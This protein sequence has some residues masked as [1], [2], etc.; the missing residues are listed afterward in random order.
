MAAATDCRF[1][2]TH[3]GGQ[4]TKPVPLQRGRSLMTCGGSGVPQESSVSLESR[5]KTLHME[6]HMKQ[7]VYYQTCFS[8]DFSN[9]KK[10]VIWKYMVTFLK[11][12]DN[13]V[14][15]F[16][17]HHY[18]FILFDV[19]FPSLGRMCSRLYKPA[20]HTTSATTNTE[21]C[22]PLQNLTSNVAT[23]RPLK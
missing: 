14:L 22:H 1:Q 15:S 16:Y 18:S 23:T 2:G 11:L 6:T 9:V 21:E 20:T 17:F 19:V 5:V 10:M 12:W 4:P 8:V 3:K 13:Y 7:T